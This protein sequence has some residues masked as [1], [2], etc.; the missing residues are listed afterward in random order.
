MKMVS[1]LT[2][3]EKAEMTYKQLQKRKKIRERKKKWDFYESLRYRVEVSS[4]Y[5]KKWGEL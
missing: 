2:N 5:Q 4:R 3:K 1:N